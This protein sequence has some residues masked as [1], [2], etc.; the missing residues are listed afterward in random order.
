VMVNPRDKGF[1][2]ER[3]LIKAANE[4]G[5]AAVRA[6]GSNGKALGE[7]EKVDLII[8]GMKIQARR[9]KT[10]AKYLQIPDG[11]DAVAMRA[12]HG[13]TYIILRYRDVLNKLQAGGW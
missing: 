2:Y 13:E 12:D 1:G 10:I 4:Y 3:E 6:W 7:S 11:V 5:L 8:Q 9:R